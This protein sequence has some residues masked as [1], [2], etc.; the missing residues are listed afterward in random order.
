MAG[1]CSAATNSPLS[2]VCRS[3]KLPLR[4]DTDAYGRPT[5]TREERWDGRSKEDWRTTSAARQAQ[6]KPKPATPRRARGA[7]PHQFTDPRLVLAA[8]FA[9][10]LASFGTFTARAIAG[11]EIMIAGGK[12][13]QTAIT[14]KAEARSKPDGSFAVFGAG[15]VTHSRSPPSDTRT[16]PSRCRRVAKC[17][18]R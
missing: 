5:H 17:R 10:L 3:G 4:S 7:S 15:P 2:V 1:A 11:R 12:G 16:L 9:V 6:R 14:G 18:W 8:A 13:V